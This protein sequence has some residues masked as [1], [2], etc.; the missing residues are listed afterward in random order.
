M[1]TEAKNDCKFHMMEGNINFS[2]LGMRVIVLFVSVKS[3]CYSRVSIRFGLY[4]F[5]QRATN[6]YLYM[7]FTAGAV[8]VLYHA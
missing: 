1:Y 2:N 6:F 8:V 7:A 3:S 4:C 5:S